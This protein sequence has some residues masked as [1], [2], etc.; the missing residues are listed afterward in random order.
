MRVVRG[1]QVWPHGNYSNRAFL[2]RLLS[3]I[4]QHFID[5]AA[6]DARQDGVRVLVVGQG[7]QA[8]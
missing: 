8:Y 7:D 4:G 3:V 5:C 1:E 2:S 6:S